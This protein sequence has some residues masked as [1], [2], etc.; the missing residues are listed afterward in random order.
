MKCCYEE[1]MGTDTH[2]TRRRLRLIAIISVIALVATACGD[3]DGD[4]DAAVTTAAAPTEEAPVEETGAGP[5][6]IGTLLP[7]T[8]DL[9]FLGPPEVAGARLACG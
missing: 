8:G 7:V 3:G 9:A 4:E 2:R 1:R 6:V 5:L